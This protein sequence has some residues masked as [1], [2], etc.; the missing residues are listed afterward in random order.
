MTAEALLP[1]LERVQALL[2][3][4]VGIRRCLVAFSGG[5]DSHVL[6]LAAHAA[7]TIRNMPIE[8]IHVHHGLHADADAWSQHCRSVCANLQVS[9][10]CHRVSV[11]HSGEGLEAA[12]REARYAVFESLLAAGDCLLMAH[13]LDDQVETFFLRLMR[14][15]GSRGLSGMPARRSLGQGILCRPLL[16]MPRTGLHEIGRALQLDW[17][18]DDS[19]RD[20][21]FDRNFLRG[22][23][24]PS[25][26]R[27][28]PEYRR[29]VESALSWQSESSALNDDLA[30]IDWQAHEHEQMPWG[31]SLC[32]DLLMAMPLARRKNLLRFWCRRYT[33]AAPGD[34]WLEQAQDAVIAARDDAQPVLPW[35]NLL[36]RRYNGRLYLC[37]V[38]E[39]D[40]VTE[41][42]FDWAEGGELPLALGKLRWQRC[43]SAVKGSIRGLK[44]PR[45][46]SRDEV[47]RLRPSGDSHSRS[48]KKF[49]QAQN[50]PPWIRP[51]LPMLFDGAE[52]VAI[53]GLC[54]CEGFE[55]REG[56]AWR[57]DWQW[58]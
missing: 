13:H 2:D 11:E 47:E 3:S 40:A 5:L 57:L 17:I 20:L 25:L 58:I 19:N 32:I 16:D 1:C 41:S 8:A 52:L 21:R 10:Q 56:D 27:R 18:E 55:G 34:A 22:E 46:G 54:V 30:L 9:V 15:A 44:N 49:L 12:A 48:L 39:M 28:W 45:I 6:L 51:S 50:I 35:Q 7:C 23:V 24:L 31:P 42:G 29:V 36:L 37:P 4:D 43:D 33:G 14:G 26:E 53:P 38:L